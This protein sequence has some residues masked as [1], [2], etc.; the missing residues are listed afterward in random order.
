MKR[1]RCTRSVCGGQDRCATVRH[2]RT[3]VFVC[4]SVTGLDRPTVSGHFLLALPKPAVEQIQHVSE[5]LARELGVVAVALVTAE[6]MLAVHF[7]PREAGS[8]VFESGVDALAALTR[9]MRI[10]AAPDHQ[11]LAANLP[12]PV[13]RVIVHTLAET[14]LVDIGGVEA[15]RCP[16]IGIE[17]GTEGKMAADTD[18]DRPELAGARGVVGEKVEDG[19]GVRVVGSKLFSDLVGV[20][21]V[22]AR[23]VVGEDDTRILLE[24]VE[25]LRTATV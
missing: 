6:R 19:T 2:V 14:A 10:L 20:A 11:Q 1:A 17:G 24:L 8:G 7:H 15:G 18:P 22:G 13:Q 3:H 21:P 9:D 4:R 25:D 12:D 23:R 16:D 5:A